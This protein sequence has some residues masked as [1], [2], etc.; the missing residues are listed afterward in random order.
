MLVCG[1]ATL[2]VAL[3]ALFFDIIERLSTEQE[4]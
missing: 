3:P 2:L 1:G 4:E